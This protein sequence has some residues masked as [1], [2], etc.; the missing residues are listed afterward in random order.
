M[1]GTAGGDLL[2]AL[3]PD[4]PNIQY[5]N[6]DPN[7][8]LRLGGLWSQYDV[9]ANP[10]GNA[11]YLAAYAAAT[12][13]ARQISGQ[14]IDWL[15]RY[16]TAASD[17][18]GYYSTILNA[19]KDALGSFLMTP[20][21]NRLT[22]ERKAAQARAGY[23]GQGAGT[24]DT[25]LNER[26]LQQLA[27]QAVPNLLSNTTAAYGTAGNIAQQEFLNRMG[28]IGSG[29]QYRQLDI[30]A[31]RYLEPTRLARADIQA[32]L[33][34]LAA[35]ANQEDKNR[36]YYRKR[37]GLEKAGQALNAFQGGLVNEANQALDLY[38]R[39]YSG[40][41]MGG[42]GGMGGGGAGGMAGMF[43]GGNSQLPT[44]RYSA[45]PYSP[46]YYGNPTTDIP[47]DWSRFGQ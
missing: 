22:A 30:P 43:G 11:D 26:I 38:S 5:S 41:L 9:S 3:A 27:S 4:R 10:A 25:L 17:P 37:S 19:N 8:A 23:G 18:T 35:I 28:I 40:G 31:L 46:N 14:N 24:Y 20:A 21:L 12:P 44:N 33:G 39:V 42:G 1:A 15:N 7:R 29:E 36:A 13:Q 45:S 2:L 16:V 6:V 32:N 34:N 47:Y